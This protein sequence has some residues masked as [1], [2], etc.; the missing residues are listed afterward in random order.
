MFMLIVQLSRIVEKPEVWNY[1]QKNS[2]KKL[3]YCLCANDANRVTRLGDFSPIR[4]LFSL[5]SLLKITEVAQILGPRFSTVPVM[6]KK[7]TKI[8]LGYIMGSFFT[9]S[10]G[11]TGCQSK[12]LTK[13]Y[14]SNDSCRY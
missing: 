9:I 10:S 12:F 4:L 5:A 3:D 13:F 8:W 6:L 11:H 2:Q 7:I 1:G 14:H